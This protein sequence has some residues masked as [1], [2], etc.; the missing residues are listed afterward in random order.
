ML[1]SLLK[2][3]LV[4]W[5]LM[6]VSAW[7]KLQTILLFSYSW[8]S[9]IRTTFRCGKLVSRKVSSF[10]TLNKIKVFAKNIEN[11][12]GKLSEILLFLDCDYN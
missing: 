9:P 4:V 10:L 3:S 5:N 1:I 7:L 2:P 11:F 8:L 6:C 12:L